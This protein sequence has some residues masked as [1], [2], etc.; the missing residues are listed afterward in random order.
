MA[1]WI[2]VT[3]VILSFVMAWVLPAGAIPHATTPLSEQT[4]GRLIP[5]GT[6]IR[7]AMLQS[8]SSAYSRAG[9]AFRFR[10]VDDVRSG[11]RIAIPAGTTGSGKVIE[12]R[13]ARAGR[14]DGRLH[15]DFDPL[16][17]RDGTKVDVAITQQ[18]LVADEN[19]HNGMAGSLEQ[20]ADMAIPG[21]FLIDFLRRGD[22]ATLAENSPFHIGVTVD[23]FL[24]N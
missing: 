18:S 10:I 2:S 4:E 1:R 11:N 7:I 20:V 8:I 24:T 9:Q 19:L 12:S 6:L 21:F 22:N 15:V 13:P 23:A 16:A 3:I 17:L 14:E 5:A